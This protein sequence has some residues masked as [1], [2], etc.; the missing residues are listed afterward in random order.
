MRSGPSTPNCLFRTSSAVCANRASSVW[1][2]RSSI[3]P[4]S[5]TSEPRR[6]RVNT[7]KPSLRSSSAML[8]DSAGCDR[9]RAAAARLK[10]P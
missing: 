8:L 2:L 4:Y 5:F 10:D 6:V 1:A 7:D 9:P 3:L